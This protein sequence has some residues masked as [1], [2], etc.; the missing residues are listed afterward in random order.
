M[1]YYN[2]DLYL[3]RIKN[4]YFHNGKTCEI[5]MR[6]PPHSVRKDHTLFEINLQAYRTSWNCSL[7]IPS[8]TY[9]DP[10]KVEQTYNFQWEI[11]TVQYVRFVHHSDKTLRR[12]HCIY[13]YMYRH[14]ERAVVNLKFKTRIKDETEWSSYTYYATGDKSKSENHDLELIDGSTDDVQIIE[15]RIHSRWYTLHAIV[16]GRVTKAVYRY[17]GRFKIA[18]RKSEVDDAFTRIVSAVIGWAVVREWVAAVWPLYLK[19]E[20]IFEIGFHDF[21]IWIRYKYIYRS[22]TFIITTKPSTFIVSTTLK[23]TSK[24]SVFIFDW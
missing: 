18:V 24:F 4:Q 14:Y 19:I 13:I 15:V 11:I 5:L 21:Y 10:L 6:K 17:V 20:W 1:S 16:Y 22:T 23:F 12:K 9:W 2:T 3:R 7:V 8:Y